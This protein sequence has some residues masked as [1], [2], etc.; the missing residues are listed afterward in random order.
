MPQYDVDMPPPDTTTAVLPPGNFCAPTHSSTW[1]YSCTLDCAKADDALASKAADAVALTVVFSA[2]LMLVFMCSP[3]FF[4]KGAAVRKGSSR[5]AGLSSVG[6]SSQSGRD[7]LCEPFLW[8]KM[9]AVIAGI[10]IRLVWP[11]IGLL[12]TRPAG[13]LCERRQACKLTSG[14]NAMLAGRLTVSRAWKCEP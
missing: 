6:S 3:V 13:F 5:E 1:P 4:E 7:H 14:A 2:R 8:T 9:W 10:A 11:L 12:L